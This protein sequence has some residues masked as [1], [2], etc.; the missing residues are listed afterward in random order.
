LKRNEKKYIDDR[1]P[2]SKLLEVLF[3]R[4][5][6]EQISKGPHASERVI[7]N[8]VNPGL[9][10]TTLSRDAT[11]LTK[12]IFWFMKTALARTVEAG[13]R[14]LVASAVGGPETHGKYMSDCVIMDP[15]KFVRSEEGKVTQERVYKELMNILEQIQPGITGNI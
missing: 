6:V 3:V 11:G 15:S 14:T 1:Y 4:A 7:I 5:L 9:C 8:L 2:T 13:S 12:F 10:K